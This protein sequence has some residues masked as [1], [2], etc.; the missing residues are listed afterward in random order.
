MFCPLHFAVVCDAASGKVQCRGELCASGFLW[1]E[2]PPPE[3]IHFLKISCC[4]S[5]VCQLQCVI[6]LS[7]NVAS[8]SINHK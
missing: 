5:A 3:S 8:D 1:Y 2:C 6:F 4:L 7:I